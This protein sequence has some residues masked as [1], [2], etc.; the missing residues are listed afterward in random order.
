MEGF[1]AWTLE[2]GVRYAALHY[3]A[4]EEKR[5]D[6]AA[7]TRV[8]VPEREWLREMEMVETI[9]EGEPVYA[10]FNERRHSFE[11][12]P[13]GP[14][15][16]LLRGSK[17]VGGWDC[18]QTLVPAFTLLQIG[19]A[20]YHQVHAL[21]EVTS[22]GSE[23]MSKFAPRVASQLMKLLPG[24]WPEVEHWADTTVTTRSGA[25]GATPQDEAARHGFKLKPSSN[26]WSGRWDAVTWLLTN[27]ISEQMPRLLIDPV[28]CP[29]LLAGFQ[30]AYKFDD[31]S[32]GAVGPDRVLKCMPVK[33]MYSH[34][35][36]SLQYAALRVRKM[37]DGAGRSEWKVHELWG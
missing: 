31:Q 22:V 21:L 13:D 27:S 4:D 30:G 24:L 32:Q 20:P 14:R 19:P 35:H 34:V 29:L 11:Q 37:L 33:N 6:W 5:G 12:Y 15:I 3:L 1:G 2:N 7:R 9:Y 18:G 26:I 28:G 8:G 25:N 36:D 17:Y 23:P 10:D 16:P